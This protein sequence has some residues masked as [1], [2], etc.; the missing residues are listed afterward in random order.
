MNFEDI[1]RTLAKAEA[2]SGQL[3]PH[4]RRALQDAQDAMRFLEPHVPEIAKAE[5]ALDGAPTRHDETIQQPSTIFVLMA[6]EPHASGT[7]LGVYSTAPAAVEAAQRIDRA[8]WPDEQVIV[9]EVD[10]DQPVSRRTWMAAIDETP[11][12]I[13]L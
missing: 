6:Y 4:T 3:P 9:H 2:V 1:Q 8:L 5:A 12:S 11:G 10:V 7:L 13:V